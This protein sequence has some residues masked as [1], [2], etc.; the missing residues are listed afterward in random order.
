MPES[1]NALTKRISELER[2]LHGLLRDAPW[3]HD[4]TSASPEQAASGEDGNTGRQT[5]AVPEVPPTPPDTPKTKSPWYKSREKWEIA[6]TVLEV[7]AIPFAIGYAVVTY[8]Q[9][10]D[11]QGNF[12]VEKRPW[13]GLKEIT[14]NNLTFYGSD[15]NHPQLNVRYHL[16]NVGHGVALI[17]GVY[18]SMFAVSS[19]GEAEIRQK[20]ACDYSAIKGQSQPLRCFRTPR[21]P[22]P[23]TNFMILLL[24]PL[25]RSVIPRPE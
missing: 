17:V 4:K 7:V 3:K 12:E 9:W 19:A 1:L 23:T 6:K 5:L 14:I 20:L 21:L 11:L 25:M 13:I 2:D 22:F 18:G 10:R 15:G 16:E 8:R 24:L